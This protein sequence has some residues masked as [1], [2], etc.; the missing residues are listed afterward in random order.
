MVASEPYRAIVRP[1][2]LIPRA[3]PTLR[4]LRVAYAVIDPIGRSMPGLPHCPTI[5]KYAS[6]GNVI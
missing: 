2:R 6:P 3:F 4:S 5:A 1:D